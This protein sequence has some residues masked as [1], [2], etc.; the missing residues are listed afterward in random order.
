MKVV[1]VI[2]SFP[3]N[4][5]VIG[6]A[7]S[8]FNDPNYDYKIYCWASGSK[9][10]S[11]WGK[12]LKDEYKKHVVISG[13]KSVKSL[14]AIGII[15]EVLGFVIMHNTLFRTHRK[16]FVGKSLRSYLV[17]LL[18]DYRLMK[19]QPDVLHFEFGTFALDKIYLKRV[20]DCKVVTS[21]RGYDINYYKLDTPNVYQ[22][23]WDNVDGF[24]F[25]GN[26]LKDRAHKRGF[27]DDGKIVALVPPAI[28][29][30]LFTRAEPAKKKEIVRPVN[31]ISVG[32]VVWKKGVP[33]GL[34]AF[35]KFLEAGGQGTYH[36]VGDGP[37][38]EEVRFT[39]FE[40]SI[41]D[42]VVLHGKLKPEETKEQ[43]QQADIFLHP[44]ISEGFCNAV[45]EAQAMEIPIVCTDADGLSENI[46]DGKTGFLAPK[47]NT[48]VMAEKLLKLYQEPQLRY[49]F[50][51]NGRERVLNNFIVPIQAKQ[52]ADFYQRV[53][54]S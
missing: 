32:R 44:S 29:P 2:P 26:D 47:W 25:L 24:H 54:E 10:W 22:P 48:D 49:E 28:Y 42:K 1:S 23:V 46:V 3:D 39:A 50:G 53:Y 18:D 5:I 27:K 4:S 34:I 9:S 41:Q 6:K 8:F 12:Y 11:F 35:K 13:I 36:I 21:F 19:L 14:S 43:L 33:D 31:I 40:L 30:E 52:F 37:L 20:L 17:A 7:V 45:I 16:Q 15:L 51:Q 38:L